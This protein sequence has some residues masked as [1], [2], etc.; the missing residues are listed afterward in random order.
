MDDKG[1]AEETLPL[2]KNALSIVDK[3]VIPESVWGGINSGIYE[4]NTA[5]KKSRSF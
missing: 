1:Q 4:F 3:M 5:M 2:L